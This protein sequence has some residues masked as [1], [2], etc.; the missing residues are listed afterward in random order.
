[1]ESCSRDRDGKVAQSLLQHSPLRQGP[2]ATTSLSGAAY[3][4]AGS[5]YGTSCY[6]T[7]ALYAQA[8]VE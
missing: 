7:S 5:R 3:L 4:R 6:S 1:M 8:P 2:I